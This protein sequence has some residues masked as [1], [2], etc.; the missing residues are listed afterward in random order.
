MYLYLIPD[1]SSS[2]RASHIFEDLWGLPDSPLA[3]SLALSLASGGTLQPPDRARL[4]ARM[5]FGKIR[6]EYADVRDWL[7]QDLAL[8]WSETWLALA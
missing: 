1:S 5:G 8:P 3:A 4:L 7:A 6:F 2:R